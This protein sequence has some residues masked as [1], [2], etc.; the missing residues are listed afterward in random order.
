MPTKKNP[1][2]RKVSVSFWKVLIVVCYHRHLS[3]IIIDLKH[4]LK[5][6]GSH[7]KHWI[8]SA[9]ACYEYVMV[10]C[11]NIYL[12][13]QEVTPSMK[14]K[15]R[16]TDVNVMMTGFCFW[17]KQVRRIKTEQKIRIS[18]M[19]KKIGMQI[20]IIVSTWGAHRE[21][22][23]CINNAAHGTLALESSSNHLIIVH[24]SFPCYC[25]QLEKKLRK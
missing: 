14:K 16:Q 21:S 4:F 18:E 25:Y 11:S 10:I 9:H 20:G 23:M 22:W 3:I 1:H 17:L 7:K 5:I 6:L 15:Y 19:Q 13:M 8:F 24:N 2:H 12:N